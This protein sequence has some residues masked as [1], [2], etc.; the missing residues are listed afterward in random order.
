M[1]VF[2]VEDTTRP[3]LILP[4]PP[5]NPT[6]YDL[7]CVFCNGINYGWYTPNMLE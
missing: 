6:K 5:P 2:R 7:E 4:P 1:Q 3:Q